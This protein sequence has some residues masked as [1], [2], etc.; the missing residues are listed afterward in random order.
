MQSLRTTLG[1]TALLLYHTPASIVNMVMSTK[2]PSD[3]FYSLCKLLDQG[4]FICKIRFLYLK[5]LE[6]GRFLCEKDGFHV[7]VG[8]DFYAKKIVSWASPLPQ[9]PPRKRGGG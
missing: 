5:M 9:P 8:E 2:F 4:V 1:A 3:S 7:L 6:Y